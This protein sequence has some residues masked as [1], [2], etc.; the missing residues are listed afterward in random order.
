MW[1]AIAQPL[2]DMHR[3]RA[4]LQ[5]SAAAGVTHAHNSTA[6]NTPISFERP[7]D[8]DDD[9]ADADDDDDDDDE[10]YLTSMKKEVLPAPHPSKESP[11]RLSRGTFSARRRCFSVRLPEIDPEIDE[12]ADADTGDGIGKEVGKC[13]EADADNDAGDNPDNDVDVEAIKGRDEGSL[14]IA[15]KAN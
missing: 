10:G 7:I 9:D 13:S 8:E 11:V 12:D 15:D 2:F 3:F 1:S 4:L 6:K 14:S 5:V